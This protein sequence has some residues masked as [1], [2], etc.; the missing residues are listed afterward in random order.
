[1]Q[2]HNANERSQDGVLKGRPAYIRSSVPLRATHRK[3]GVVKGPG[4]SSAVR[5]PAGLWMQCGSDPI[6]ASLERSYAL[7]YFNHGGV[8]VPVLLVMNQ[9]AGIA[10]F[11]ESWYVS[12]LASVRNGSVRGWNS[13]VLRVDRGQHTELFTNGRK[14]STLWHAEFARGPGYRYEGL[15]L[16]IHNDKYNNFG[17]KYYDR[18]VPQLRTRKTFTDFRVF[19]KRISD[20]AVAAYTRGEATPDG[21]VAHW[22]LDAGPD[23]NFNYHDRIGGHIMH[24]WRYYGWD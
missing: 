4:A 20:S 23:A 5:T 24:V 11:S 8:D 10:L 15:Q 12:G 2:A 14:V 18:C 1:M 3:V 7:R 21:L 19:N 9:E 6:R 17:P 13:V 22:P 16:G